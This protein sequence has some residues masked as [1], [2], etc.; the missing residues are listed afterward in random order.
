MSW[1]G[2]TPLE[3]IRFACTELKG[4]LKNCRI[5][6]LY[7]TEPLYVADQAPF[8]NCA[9]C[10]VFAQDRDSALE[11]AALQL[12]SAIQDL[13][14]RCGR[15]RARERRWGERPLDIDILIFGDL[16]LES[17]ELTI[18]HPRLAE[19]RFALQ[20]LLDILPDAR[21]PRSGM[22]F[23]DMLAVLPP[24]GISC[25]GQLFPEDASQ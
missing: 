8:L 9:V 5:S 11:P 12:L 14:S 19:R 18:P 25:K 10:G 23:R 1:R 16:V 22:P 20:P 15:D 24:Q 7:E 17:G 3:L 4:I 21:D 2:K 13:E 6:G